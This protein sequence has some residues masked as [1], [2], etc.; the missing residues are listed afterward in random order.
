[1]AACLPFLGFYHPGT[2]L[3]PNRWRQDLN[4]AEVSFR[5]DAFASVVDVLRN[6]K[7]MYSP[8]LTTPLRCRAVFSAVSVHRESRS[9][10]RRRGHSGIPVAFTASDVTPPRSSPR[11][12][13]APR[14]QRRASSSTSERPERGTPTRQNLRE[15][16]WRHADV[17]QRLPL[18]PPLTGGVHCRFFERGTFFN[19]QNQQL[20]YRCTG[21]ARIRE[22]ASDYS[23]R[24]TGVNCYTS[25]HSAD[26]HCASTHTRG[27]RLPNSSAPSG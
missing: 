17:H 9:A 8:G 14:P 20:G 21:K 3:P 5:P 18:S 27:V 22:T 6:E 26:E 16:Q 2:A 12:A 10:N 24:E 1:M 13:P 25:T 7:P 11:P 4:A 19:P 15:G 23:G